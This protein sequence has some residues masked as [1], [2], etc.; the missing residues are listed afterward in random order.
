[1]QINTG[2]HELQ[3]VSTQRS[4]KRNLSKPAHLKYR[5]KWVIAFHIPIYLLS[6]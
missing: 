5:A 3:I 4:S 6:K 1:M 2:L